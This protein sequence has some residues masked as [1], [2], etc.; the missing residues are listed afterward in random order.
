MDYPSNKK[1]ALIISSITAVL[2]VRLAFAANES[3]N[4]KGFYYSGAQV[5]IIAI[6]AYF[7]LRRTHKT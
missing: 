3:F 1:F 4:W 7:A 2:I 5:F 6:G